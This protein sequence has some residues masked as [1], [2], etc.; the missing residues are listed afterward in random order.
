MKTSKTPPGG[1]KL[2]PPRQGFACKIFL[3]KNF[4]KNFFWYPDAGAKLPPPPPGGG[5]P[6]PLQPVRGWREGVNPDAVLKIFL[7]PPPPPGG[8]VPLQP[9]RAEGRG[10]T[11]T[12]WRHRRQSGGEREKINY[13]LYIFFITYTKLNILIF[14]YIQFS[15]SIKY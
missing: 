15:I 7:K 13:S 2:P 8:G 6:P 10:V 3:K 12:L 14:I 9:V 4:L 1:A 11:L 5:R